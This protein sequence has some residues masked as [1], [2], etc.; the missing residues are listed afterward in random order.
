MVSIW[1]AIILS[2]CCLAWAGAALATVQIV[3]IVMFMLLLGVWSSLQFSC[4]Y[5]DDPELALLLER[6][7]IVI[8]CAALESSSF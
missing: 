6:C 8:T 5:R 2:S 4:I 1:T 7:E 3:I